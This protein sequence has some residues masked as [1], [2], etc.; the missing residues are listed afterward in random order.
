MRQME[1]SKQKQKQKY[2]QCV[3]DHNMG[4]CTGK[5]TKV[6][7]RQR[8]IDPV[9][10][11]RKED[12]DEVLERLDVITPRSYV[13]VRDTGTSTSS[14]MI[15]RQDRECESDLSYLTTGNTIDPRWDSDAGSCFSLSPQCSE[16][17]FGSFSGSGCFSD[18]DSS[19]LST[20]STL[21]FFCDVGTE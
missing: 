4:N 13:E 16:T 20:F 11:S 19:N 18:S 9:P 3:H 15:C 10:I 6:G 21:T 14:P 8:V 1:P 2:L 7:G 17:S 12:I 5:R